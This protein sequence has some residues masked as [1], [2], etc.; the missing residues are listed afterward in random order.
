M[1]GARG[2]ASAA[3]SAGE[4]VA[5]VRQMYRIRMRDRLLGIFTRAVVRLV[6]ICCAQA[7]LVVFSSV[8]LAVLLGAYTA[9]RLSMNT[10][11]FSLIDPHLP[12][13]QREIANN[14]AFPRDTDQLIIVID[15]D[16]PAVADEAAD[17]LAA[18]LAAD[19]SH[20]K[21]VARPGGGEF[22]RRNGLLFLSIEELTAVSDRIVA[23]QPLIGSL[24]ADPTLRGLFA[25]LNLALEGV[26]RGDIDIASLEQPIEAIAGSAEA[27]RDG[28]LQ[29]LPWRSLF[30]GETL[31]ANDRRR[32]LVVQP[33]LDYSALAPGAEASAVV[34]KAAAALGLTPE[35]GVRIRLTGPVALADEE[36]VGVFRG[37]AAATALSIGLVVLLLYLALRSV[38]LVVAVLATLSVGFI[39]TAAFAAAAIGSLNL[40]SVAFGVMF[41]GLAVDFS[42]Q[43]CTRY[44]DE[45]YRV[46]ELSG[47]LVKAARG[48][49]GPLTLA[50]VATALGFWSFI[51]TAYIGVSELGLIAGTGM[52]IALL[53]NVS[54]L[55]AL[56]ALLH[57][58]GERSPAGYIWAAGLDT[59]LLRWRRWVGIAAL[60]AG[61]LSLAILPN[62]RFD[63]NPLNLRDPGTESVS[64]LLDLMSDPLVAAQTV[65]VVTASPAAAAA[66]A[67]RLK[68]LP[69]VARVVSINSFIPDDQDKKLAVVEDLAS[70]LGPALAAPG[71]SVAPSDAEIQ[72]SIAETIERL[73]E[74]GAEASN[75]AASRLASALGA[76]LER[77]PTSFI[78]LHDSLLSG[79]RRE[80]E[81]LRLA[82]EAQPVRLRDLPRDL[83]ESWLSADGRARIQ[84]FPAGD[85]RDS[86]TIHRFVASVQT[87]APEATGDAVANYEGGQVVMRAFVTAGALALTTITLVLAVVLRRVRDVILV[88]VPLVLAGALTLATCALVGL[89]INFANIIA[90]PLLLG[91]GVAFSV[92]LVM[93]WRAGVQGQLQSPTARALVFSAL[94]T[95]SAFGSLVLS[96]HPGTASMGLLLAMGLAY[97]VACTM[98]VLPALLGSVRHERG[99]GGSA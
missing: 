32:I 85:P 27:A 80:L 2:A 42:I 69:D 84:V 68:A 1:R 43:F 71:M 99:L 81:A 86:D 92:Y 79:L 3:D 18:C 50:A 61:L 63:A 94:T 4:A 58:P 22:F 21:T 19:T 14:Q 24:A 34:R 77:G 29:P 41:V 74:S 23:A 55:P 51:P 75:V 20:F 48:L 62:L 6:E 40:I 83:V 12:W 70:L 15:G 90:L 78:P 35:R 7:H 93:N 9:S 10:D 30:M 36:L 37:T 65:D 66:L 52:I 67:P 28:N 89:P 45:R 87:V 59:F 46:G 64:T 25:A 53:L 88:L 76:V 72:S 98:F 16:A 56:L 49:A 8:V 44:R 60:A 97:E 5:V 13:R 33:V 38:R 95:G 17:R 57:P 96:S 82:L 39:A 54:L 47:A 11:T 26:A 73:R 31:G 91:I